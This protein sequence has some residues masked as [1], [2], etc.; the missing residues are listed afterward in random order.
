MA[1]EQEALAVLR[2]HGDNLM[3]RYGAFACGVRRAD[4][5]NWLVVLTVPGKPPGP[6]FELE[7]V[8]VRFESGEPL[9]PI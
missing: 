6:A 7:G 5:R 8:T 1:D 3:Q 9:F 4:D 2:K